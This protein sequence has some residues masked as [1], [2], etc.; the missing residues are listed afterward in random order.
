M[1]VPEIVQE[2]ELNILTETE[3]MSINTK[4]WNKGED[5]WFVM[6][7]YNTVTVCG[8]FLPNG[9]HQTDDYSCGPIAI[10]HFASLLKEL[11]NEC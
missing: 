10:N 9:Y 11:P 1:H 5:T 8:I 6:E 2:D 4:D 3:Q 7:N